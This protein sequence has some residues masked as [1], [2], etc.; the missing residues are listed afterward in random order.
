MKT[1]FIIFV[2]TFIT[3]ML[4]AQINHTDVIY[5]KNGNV[6]RG[7]IIEEVPNISYKIKTNDNNIFECKIEEI[8]KLTREFH[9]REA[10][11]IPGHLQPGYRRIIEM[12]HEFQEDR[13]S[14]DRLKLNLI[15]AYQLNPFIS[16]GIGTGIRYYYGSRGV[17]VPLFADFRTHFMNTQISPYLALGMGYTFDIGYEFRGMGILISPSA[18]VSFKAFNKARMNV[19]IGYEI[20][21]VRYWYSRNAVSV[22]LGISF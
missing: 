14:T 19:G 13:W 22:N 9:T 20:Q 8:E 3:S 21:R 2:C 15:N 4:C 6:Y 17:A 1:L 10:G 5:L 11:Y 12:G 7:I 18:G 16:L